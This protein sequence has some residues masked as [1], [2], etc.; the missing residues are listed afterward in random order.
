MYSANTHVLYNLIIKIT[1][2]DQNQDIADVIDCN[3]KITIV[4]KPNE[5]NA[6]LLKTTFPLKFLE[7]F[8]V[9]CIDICT[10]MSFITPDNIW[11]SDSNDNLILTNTS[12][13]NLY[14]VQCYRNCYGKHTVSSDREVIYIQ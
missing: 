11:V 1:I 12:D 9:Q 6:E 14:Q 5:E 2:V 8:F 10:H 4:A 13:E 7:S 3:R